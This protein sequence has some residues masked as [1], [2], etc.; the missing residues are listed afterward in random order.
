MCLLRGEVLKIWYVVL[1]FR[2]L[3]AL[4]SKAWVA[5]SELPEDLRLCPVS[6]RD[7]EA[8]MQV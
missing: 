2:V 7:E 3:K 1:K 5:N 4:S 6:Q 8:I